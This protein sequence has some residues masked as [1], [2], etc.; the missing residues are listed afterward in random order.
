MAM[1]P[2]RITAHLDPLG[3]PLAMPDGY[4]HIDAL[5]AAAVCVRDNVPPI[6]DESDILPIEIPVQRE[7]G[8]RFHLAS[9]SLPVDWLCHEKRYT[10]RRFPVEHAPYMTDMKRVNLAAGA[11]K[12]FRIPL[13]NGR[14]GALVWYLIGELVEIRQLLALISHLGKRRGVGY[15]KV[16]RWQV[17]ECETWDGFPVVRDGQPL[18]HLPPDWP[19][20]VDP[21][22]RLGN[23][24]YPYWRRSTEQE[25]AAPC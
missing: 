20:L 5:L 1:T 21:A 8:G 15:G 9:A 18:R 14:V 23:T 16:S 2:L 17:D 3:A 22:L 24:S 12:N 10:Q 4:L 11:Q 19:G 6:L 13:D 25:I 7:P